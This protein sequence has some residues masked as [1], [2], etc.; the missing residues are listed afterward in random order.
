MYASRLY[1][2]NDVID[3]MSFHTVRVLR[4]LPTSWPGLLC[5]GVSQRFIDMSN[6]DAYHKLLVVSLCMVLLPLFVMYL[7]TGPLSGE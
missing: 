2:E 6:E 7:G 3:L 4:L 5:L 1:H